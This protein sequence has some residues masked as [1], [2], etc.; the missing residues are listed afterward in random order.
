MYSVHTT[1][2]VFD[3]TITKGGMNVVHLRITVVRSTHVFVVR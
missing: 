3:G 2:Y 1:H